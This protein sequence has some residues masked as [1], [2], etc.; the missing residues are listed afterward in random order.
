MMPKSDAESRQAENARL[1]AKQREIDRLKHQREVF[2]GVVGFLAFNTA[3][4]LI[5]KAIF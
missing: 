4:Y 5:L 3:G 2:F 1:H